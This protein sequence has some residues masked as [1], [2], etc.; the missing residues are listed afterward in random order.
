MNCL[1]ISQSNIHFHTS[2]TTTL[3]PLVLKFLPFS[4]IL[5]QGMIQTN[6]IQSD[7]VPHTITNCHVTK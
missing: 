3:Q 7:N 6:C 5:A 4:I 2:H 1:E